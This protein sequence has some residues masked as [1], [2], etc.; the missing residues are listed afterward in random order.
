MGGF[1]IR[2]L[3][4]VGSNQKT[5]VLKTE[6]L[7]LVVPNLYVIAINLGATLTHMRLLLS[8][9]IQIPEVTLKIIR[10]I[11]ITHMLLMEVFPKIRVSSA[12]NK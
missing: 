5:M 1:L 4:K 8:K 2:Q 3:S 10:T 9:F 12:Y 6:L 7:L 11:S